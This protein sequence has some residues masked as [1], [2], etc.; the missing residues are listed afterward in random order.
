MIYLQD[1]CWQSYMQCNQRN[2]GMNCDEL[3][4]LIPDLVDGSLSPERRAEAEIALT[5]CPDCQ[6]EL[7]IAR[8]SRQ[9]LISLQAEHPELH[10]PAGFEAR[11]MAQIKRQN[12]SLEF[13]DLSSKAFGVWLVELI[14][15]IGGLLDPAHI[16]RPNRPG[17]EPTGA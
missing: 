15:L 16:S 13:L 12:S 11:L 3:A 17:P 10:V 1:R 8:Q 7:K 4:Q 9:L 5:Q 6:R 14:N 2:N